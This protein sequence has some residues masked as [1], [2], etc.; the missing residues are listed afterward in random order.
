MGAFVGELSGRLVEVAVSP[1][2]SV[3]VAVGEEVATPVRA[4][5][6]SR[7]LTGR[8]GMSAI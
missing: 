3:G 8:R 4:V 5:G 2:C 7:G 6:V 1:E